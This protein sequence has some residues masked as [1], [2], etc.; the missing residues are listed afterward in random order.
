MNGAPETATVFL[1]RIRME[2]ARSNDEERDPKA[3]TG[4]ASKAMMNGS[5]I[6]GVFE[7]QKDMFSIRDG[8]DCKWRGEDCICYIG[9]TNPRR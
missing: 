2:I 4:T 8:D 1:T 9:T 7:L 5:D 3:V 6:S